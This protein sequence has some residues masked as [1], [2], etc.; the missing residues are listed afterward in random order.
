L[1]R[2]R[3]LLQR[4]A[5]GCEHSGQALAAELGISRAAVW[6]QLRQLSAWGLEVEAV[7]GR[8]Y[9]LAAPLDLLDEAALRAGLPGRARELLRQL[10]L[11]DEMVSTN[12]TLL[13]VTDL[14]PG[15]SDACLAEF[16]SQGRGRRGRRWLAP[17]ASGIC[18]SVNR[19]F[20]EAPPQLSALS[21]AAGVAV[22]RALAGLGVADVELKWPND[23][24][25]GGRKL[26]GILCEL[27]VEAAGPAYVVVGVG[28]N[29]RL[30]DASHLLIRET[31]LEA[32]S[33]DQLGVPPPARSALAAA[34]LTQ[35]L[36]ALEEFEQAGFS[37]FF[38]EWT[39]ADAMSAQ[40]V[41]VE[42]GEAVIDGVAR[43]IDLD[44]AL[45]LEV[46]GR[47]E[48]FVSGEASLRAGA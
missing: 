37:P 44:G 34:L 7:P 24:L 21:L 27:R 31:G 5:D 14:Q 2:R 41:R 15:L 35:L 29:V 32:A 4:L 30:P 11:A 13:A 23:V 26:G 25:L 22:R 42:R 46:G 6:K 16:Q 12:E 1:N 17:F 40:A 28:L 47:L 3:E 36:L 20:G 8:G 38:D 48:R 9:R 10:I 19:C 39:A 45:L 43:G 33:L 18:L